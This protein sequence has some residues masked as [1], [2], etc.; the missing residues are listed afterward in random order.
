MDE[1]TGRREWVYP[2]WVKG[3]FQNLRKW[4]FVALQAFLFVTPWIHL[5]GHQIIQFDL[6]ARQ[7]HVAGSIY[8]AQDT[9][10]LF[11]VL[12]FLALLLFFVTSLWGRIW[13]GYACPQTVFLE[14]W[15]HTVERWIEGHR[16]QRMALDKG[17]WTAQKV[18]KKA[19]KWTIFAAISVVISMTFVSWFAGTRALWTGQASTGAYG[20]VAFF[21]GVM[22]LDLAWFR[23]QFCNFLCP[24]ARFQGVIAGPNSLV[25]TYDEARGEPRRQ[26]G[27]KIPKEQLGACIDCNK[28][29]AV[30]PTGIDIRDGYQLECIGCAK[31]VDAC[32]PIMAKFNQET[33]VRYSTEVEEKGGE[34]SLVRPRP[35]LY[36]V[37]LIVTALVFV[38]LLAARH[39][40]D[41]TVNR[42]P[43]SLYTVDP[44][45]MVRNTFI[46]QVGNKQFVEA[47][48]AI[49]V[50]VEGLDDI[51]VIVPPVQLATG[52]SV[53][54]PLVIR[55]AHT[56]DLPRTAPLDIRV[57]SDFDEVVVKTTF[58]TDAGVGG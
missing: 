55:H 18:G 29:V 32:T 38:G 50:S 6:P 51:E 2:A 46:L 35:V 53:K 7:L 42:A 54:V 30:C 36:A 20:A 27:V 44:D 17:P 31:C 12:F 19:A 16:G 21:A 11:L 13:C 10:F 15:V 49:T 34:T 47:P 8:S 14:T 5:R 37:G 26:K 52:Q 39:E 43:G 22:F 48:A 33:L 58:K 56:D 41:V 1:A 25:I 57:R 28:C 45:G 24:Y 23:E 40:L 9:I 3:H 4:S